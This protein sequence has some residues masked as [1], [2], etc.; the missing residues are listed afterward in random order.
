[1]LSKQEVPSGRCKIVEVNADSRA[2]IRVGGDAGIEVIVLPF[3]PGT[4]EGLDEVGS[5]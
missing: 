2:V 1:M 4:Y 5:G 3:S